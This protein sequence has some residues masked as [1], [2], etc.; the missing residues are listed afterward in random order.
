MKI[1]IADAAERLDEL[2]RRAEA[3]EEVVL[4]EGDREV[5]RLE[6]ITPARPGADGTARSNTLGEFLQT[7]P[8]CGA[9]I[10]VSRL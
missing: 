8:L 10:D 7:S 1:Q 3:G 2:V 6:R 4:A 5:A 9:A